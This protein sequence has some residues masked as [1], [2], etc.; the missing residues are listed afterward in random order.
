MIEF[1]VENKEVKIADLSANGTWL[2]ARRLPKGSKTSSMGTSTKTTTKAG[3]AILL[4]HGDEI[5][6]NKPAAEGSTNSKLLGP[7]GGAMPSTNSK[8]PGK[9]GLSA[10]DLKQIETG[11]PV[12]SVSTAEFAFVVNMEFP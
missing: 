11:K 5:T 8:T 9:T 7:G 4:C 1:D 2:N 3:A 10:E 6:F 12:A